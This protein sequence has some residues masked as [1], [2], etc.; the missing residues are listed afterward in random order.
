MTLKRDGRG[1]MRDYKKEYKRDQSSAKQRK[2]RS[3]RNKARRRMGLK[4]GDK[5]QVHHKDG[6]PSN[7]KRSNLKLM[8]RKK[9][10]TLSNK[11][12]AKRGRK[13]LKV[14]KKR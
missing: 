12:R 5:R 2:R 7:N 13:R 4:V 8:S 1:R 14:K 3:N 10:T 6:N 11:K 9:N